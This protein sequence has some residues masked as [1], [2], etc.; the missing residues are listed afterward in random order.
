MKLMKRPNKLEHL[1]LASCSCL[2]F[3]SKARANPRNVLQLDRLHP[4]RKYSTALAE[5]KRSSL[6]DVLV[7]GEEK[8]RFYDLE[9][10]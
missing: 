4:T 10:C 9:S 8:K 5:D 6:F 1:L 7:S 3:V 2:I